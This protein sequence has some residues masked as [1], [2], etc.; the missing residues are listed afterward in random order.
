MDRAKED[1]SSEALI[2]LV[3]TRCDASELFEIAE[4][5]LYEMPPAIHGEV[6]GDSVLAIRFRWDDG[7]GFCFAEQFTQTI[8]VEPL[9]GQQRLHVDA[10]DQVGCCDAVVALSGKQNEFGKVSER[11]DEGNDLC[12][13]SAAR[14]SDGLMARPPFAPMP[15]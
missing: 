6:A 9:V 12:C 4:E 13:Q 2:R 14:A 8:V 5:V 11:I 10:I 1:E 15:C 7:L 3:V